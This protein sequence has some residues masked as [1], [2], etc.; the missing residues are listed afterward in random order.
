MNTTTVQTYWKDT[1]E[2]KDTVQQW[3]DRIQFRGNRE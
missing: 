2:L 3:S 1:E